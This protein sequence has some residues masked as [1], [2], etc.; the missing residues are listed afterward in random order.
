MA[1]PGRRNL[2]NLSIGVG[3]L[4]FFRTSTATIYTIATTGAMLTSRAGTLQGQYGLS[5]R[6]RLCIRF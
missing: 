6:T 5:C 3:P 1:R 4:S 2:H